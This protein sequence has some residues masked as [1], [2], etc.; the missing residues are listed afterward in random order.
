[1]DVSECR[2]MITCSRANRSRHD[3]TIPT[4]DDDVREIPQG[5]AVNTPTHLML[6]AAALTK[7]SEEGESTYMMPAMVGAILPDAPMFVFY[8][9]EKFL[10]GSSEREIW[11]TRY[12]LESWQN[13]FDLFNS[14]PIVLI[15]M[16]VAWKVGHRGWMILLASMLLHIAA[17]LP[18]HHDDGHRHFWPLS[19]WRF[20]SPVSYWDPNHFGRPAAVLEVALFIACYFWSM[21]KHRQWKNRIGLSILAL[22]HMGFLAFALLVWGP[23]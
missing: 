21:R 3:F 10:L 19:D 2:L 9:V 12:F 23:M 13:F 15:G 18:L 16:L 11:T 5:N 1:M 20:E 4:S 7:R 17:D 8:A 22:V 14:V 6:S